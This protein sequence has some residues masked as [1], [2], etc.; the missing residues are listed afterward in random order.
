MDA[1]SKPMTA[2]EVAALLADGPFAEAW[3]RGAAL[4]LSGGDPQQLVYASPAALTMFGA[5][6]LEALESAIF[7]SASPGARRLRQLADTL[8]IGGAP[9]L[10]QLRFYRGRLPFACGLVCGRIETPGGGSWLVAVSPAHAAGE[11]PELEPAPEMPAAGAESIAAPF[12]PAPIV[13]P[14]R[15]VWKLDAEDR[16]SNIDP[17]LASRLGPHAPLAG[18]SLAQFQA[19]V[20]LEPSDAWS[21]A[22]A[23]RA[24]FSALR[25]EW[26][27]YGGARARVTRIS[28]AP[29]FDRSRNYAG[30][31]GFGILTPESFE[32]APL[33]PEAQAPQDGLGLE[34]VAPPQEAAGEPRVETFAGTAPEEEAGLPDS[35]E[36]VSGPPEAAVAP[37]AETPAPVTR[38]GAEIVML[39]PANASPNVVPIRP[40]ALNVLA[41]P[42]EEPEPP[43]GEESVSLT[44]QERDA[45]REIARALGV[46]VRP[47]RDT[48]PDGASN[49]GSSDE[50]AHPAADV[51][52]LIAPAEAE[53]ALHQPLAASPRD[54]VAALVD[55]LPVGALVVRAGEALY[56]NRSLLDFVGF[57]TLQAFRAGDGVKQIF[58]GRDPESFVAGGSG[59]PLVAADGELAMVHALS[60]PISW[61][62]APATLIA[63]RRSRDA[64]HQEQLRSTEHEAREHAAK[65]RDLMAA[66]DAA[67]DG[68]VRLDASGRI[69]A[70]SARAEV[71]FGY[72]QKETAGESFLMLLAPTSQAAA[73]AAL[74]QATKETAS[75]AARSVEVSAR[76]RGGRA[77]PARLTLGRMT[78]TVDPEFFAIVNDLTQARATERDRDAARE[79]AEKI[80]ARKTE[81]LATVSHEIRTP[82]HAILGFTEVMIEERFGPIGNERYKDY[83]KDIHASGQHVMSL[84]NDLLDLAKIEAGKMELQ[85][86]PVDANRI[87][88]ECV[89]LMQPQAARERIIVRLSLFDKLPNVMADERS[90]RQIIL[91]LMSNAVKYNEPGGQVIVSTALDEAG[92]AIIRVR[93]TGVGMNESELG[94]AL[95][96][97]KRVGGGRHDEGTGLGLPLTKALADANHADF[98][99][100]SRKD[101]GTLVEVAFPSVQAAQ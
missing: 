48:A 8:P 66:L 1:A 25:V 73:T 89:A 34:S 68:M 45:F 78:S 49:G 96:P 72:D 87:I 50:P 88:R 79:A 67:A 10:E 21:A 26:T 32:R 69:L 36:A 60:R 77:F 37:P 47:P 22:V 65:A 23:A 18:E 39:R 43:R 16:F 76:D 12:E 82:L 70:M 11:A 41:P 84:A 38:A 93:D 62:G 75:A 59:V 58:R 97:F 7:Q 101:Q 13:G 71:L 63:L 5:T 94:L 61:Q 29:Q 27:E 17:A 28:G 6:S 95:E 92:H 86:A 64:E 4:T 51:E 83:L 40:G 20:R 85:F 9:R 35:Y 52:S 54:D 56:A 44:S 90:L 74:E 99:I 31:L 33:E 53:A 30:F 2:R 24:T 55:V 19:R 100:K 3:A 81:F 14:V 46:R 91:N 57:A 15:F 98:S 80:S 42:P